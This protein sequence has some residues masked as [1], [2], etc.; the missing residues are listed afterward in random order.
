[1]TSTELKKRIIKKI[2]KINDNHLLSQFND[3]LNKIV[4]DEEI[5]WDSLSPEEKKSI[6]K[7]L[8][9]LN[10]GEFI[11]YDEVK[12]HFPGWLKK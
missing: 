3:I 1:M 6:E 11:E 8:N 9:Q 4:S 12:K 10:R 5:S 7:G 2:D